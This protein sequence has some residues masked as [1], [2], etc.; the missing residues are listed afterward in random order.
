MIR[1]IA[2][3]WLAAVLLFLAVGL[4]MILSVQMSIVPV[5]AMSAALGVGTGIVYKLIYILYENV[6]DWDGD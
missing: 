4:S 1:T 5:R 2:R 6:A 3:L